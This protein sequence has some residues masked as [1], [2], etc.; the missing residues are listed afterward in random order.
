M[1]EV[2]VSGLVDAEAENGAG[3]VHLLGLGGWVGEVEE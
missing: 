1:G 3:L 2:F